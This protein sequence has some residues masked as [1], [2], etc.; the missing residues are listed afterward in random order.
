MNKVNLLRKIN[1]SSE[2]AIIAYLALFK[3]LIHMINPE[4][5][6]HRDE[7]F[8]LYI[9]DNY[10]FSNLDVLPLTP[11]YLKFITLLFGH[12]LKAIHF[13]SALCGTLSI[14]LTCLITKELGGKKFSILIA[15]L[16][17][18]FSGFLI[19]S[20]LFTY[21]SIDF[22]CVV[23][24]IYFL[25][26]L[27]KED[28]PVYWI[29]VGIA[30]GFGLLNKMTI[31]FFCSSIVV[32]LLI[33]P[34]RKYFRNKWIWIAAI[35][36]F[37]FFIPFIVWQI[38]N[39]WYFVDWAKYYAGGNSYIASFPEFI[40]NQILPNN[41][42][43]LPIWL[44]GLVLLIFS[45]KWKHY[46]VFGLNYIILFLLIYLLG[47]KFY[48]LIPYYTILLAVGSIKIEALVNKSKPPVRKALLISLPV[49]Y[50]ILSLVTVPMMI[51]TLS[52][53]QFA[54]YTDMI[55]MS[56]DAGV[57]YENNQL[58]E[59]IPQHFADRFGWEELT[60]K[61]SEVYSNLPEAAKDS[62]GGIICNNSGQAAAINFYRGKYGLPEAISAHGWF[63]YH[64]RQT[65]KF[66]ETYISIHENI[67][68]FKMAFEH[69]DS[70]GFFSNPYCMP[71]ETNKIIYLC[72][73]PKTDL[74]EF[75]K[76]LKH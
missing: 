20:A 17:T 28:K 72:S 31:I 60:Q 6:Y 47:G 32:V 44:T 45:K 33:T 46:R 21:D 57:R 59:M 67:P 73:T 71:Y 65:H 41:V 48:F 5:G 1:F 29:P 9:S 3:I 54:K 19:F 74:E 63:Y 56:S 62:V 53:R 7:L 22:L 24:I 64:A 40:M 38:N 18:L 75:W 68:K 51:P 2:Y 10:S 25:V 52:V 23:I 26:R 11:L 13:A 27:F 34:H 42:I 70:I 43:N 4:Y 66:R 15:G 58:N 50:F 37:L 49:L 55:G 61:I 16:S 39:N 12:S 76:T 35:I 8:F 30:I 14:V 36:S 69:V